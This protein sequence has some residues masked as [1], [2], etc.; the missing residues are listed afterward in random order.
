MK[1]LAVTPFLSQIL[2]LACHYFSIVKLILTKF[3]PDVPQ[4]LGYPFGEFRQ[5]IF[6]KFYTIDVKVNA[7]GEIH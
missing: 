1:S 4:A 2:N 7:E 6:E 3:S 5:C